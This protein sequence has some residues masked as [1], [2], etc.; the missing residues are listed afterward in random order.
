[1]PIISGATTKRTGAV[2]ADRWALDGGLSSANGFGYDGAGP[3][4]LAGF[5]GRACAYDAIYERQTWPAVGVNK[6]TRLEVVLPRKVYQR[7]RAGRE[8]ARMSPFG[9]LIAR[10]SRTINPHMFYWWFA[11]MHHIHGVSY[12]LK[13]RPDP[14]SP[15]V[16]LH[17]IHPTRL[18]YGPKG[19]GWVAPGFGGIEQAD[20]RWWLRQ[21]DNVS[22][23]A[24]NRRDF[25]M[26][27]RFSPAGPQ[28]GMSP[29]EPLRS[30]LVAEA[31]AITANA[32]MFHNGGRHD[33]LLKTPKN[34]GTGTS[35]V[36]KRL[37]DQYEAR[38]TGPVNRGRPLILEDGMDAVPLNMSNKD[39]EFVQARKLN[40]E[41]VA[42]V[43]DI[44]PPAIHI[45]DHATFSNITE[46][47]ESI[48]KLTMPDHLAGLEAAIDF[49]LRDGSFGEGS[50]DFPD[51][52]YFESLVD[53][54]LRGSFEDRMQ[55]YATMVQ[56]GVMMP[57][58][59]RER[60]NLPFVP[61]SNVLFINGAVVPI[62]QAA[63]GVSAPAAVLPAASTRDRSM[64]LGRLSRPQSVGDIDVDRLIEGLAPDAAAAVRGAVDI[65][66]F[67]QMGVPELRQ[68]IKTMGV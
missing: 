43:L 24:I 20:N 23:R 5:L 8:D 46:Q 45:L 68:I 11:A 6:L 66:R 12:A 56:N 35:M 67:G 62:D 30:T 42:S 60:E 53:G 41:E 21:A 38:H 1:M 36:L 44:P 63:G 37:A 52:V 47:F 2:A 50:P 51:A 17:L 7:G 28:F 14:K 40:R 59:I 32:A 64:V 19:G 49:D 57:S 61:G 34:F 18:R 27:A 54:V 48:Y 29:F 22:E 65:A 25:V 15:P 13:G 16:E 58:E 26:R 55:A 10:P 31:N 33:M 3:H 9:R 4:P 39:M